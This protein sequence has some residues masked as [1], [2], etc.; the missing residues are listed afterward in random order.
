MFR[1]KLNPYVELK[2]QLTAGISAAEECLQAGDMDGAKQRLE[3]LSLLS[4]PNLDDCQRIAQIY[5]GLGLPAMAG[6]FWY[7]CDDDSAEI[8]S[9][10]REFE[11]SCGDNLHVILQSLPRLDSLHRS[12]R[13]KRIGVRIWGAAAPEHTLAPTLG[14]RVALVGCA[15]IAFAFLFVFSMG[16][17]ALYHGMDFAQ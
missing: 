14:D 9:A 2:T 10:C 6:R 16:L 12:N 11:R 3:K 7:V 1:K 17:V 15:L 8:E 13:V 4:L 5:W